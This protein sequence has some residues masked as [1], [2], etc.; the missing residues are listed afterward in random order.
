MPDPCPAPSGDGAAEQLS[1]LQLPRERALPASAL[2][3]AGGAGTMKIGEVSER[4]GLSLR[5]MRHYEHEGLITPAGRTP[6]GF[7][8][9]SEFDVQ[10]L[11]LIMQMKPLGYTL[12]QMREVLTDLD[13]M[14]GRGSN[15]PASRAAARDR[16]EELS[17]DVDVR[18]AVAERR[19]AIAGMF[20]DHLQAEFEPHPPP[21]PQ[22]S[23]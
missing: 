18:Y 12:E 9:Y 7:R 20:R 8:L 17:R 4:V 13:T 5:S 3:Q 19:L 2:T 1:G 6:G 10:R 14:A 11:L 15:D 21:P 22:P 16:L 23:R